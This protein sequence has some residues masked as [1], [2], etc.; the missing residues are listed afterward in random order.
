MNLAVASKRVSS[1]GTKVKV[2]V[3]DD[4]AVVRGLTRR[5]LEEN[6][7]I[8]VV[9]TA[10][11]GQLAVDTVKQKDID[12]VVLDIEMPVMDG[13][14]AIPH[15]LAAKPSVKIVMSSTL[16]EA[17]AAVSLKALSAGASD[18]VAKPTTGSAI[19]TSDDF[20][21]ELLTKV[22]TLGG[23]AD[24][25]GSVTA[26]GAAA[27]RAAPA[28]ALY[29]GKPITLRRPSAVTPRALAI[30]SSTGGPQALQ[31]L[32]CGLDA[33]LPLPVFITQ[34]MPAT[35]TQ[36]LAEHM[37]RDSGR[38]VCEAKNGQ[39]V[40]AGD[41]YIAPGDYHMVIEGSGNNLT[42]RLTQTEREN[43]CRPSVEPMLRSLV[44]IYGP[45]LFTVILTGM[46]HDGLA[47]CQLSVEKGG[48]V[49]AQDEASSV[50][51]GMPGAVATAGVCAAVKPLS[52][53]AKSVN[54]FVKG[55]RL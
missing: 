37:A 50:V 16:T 27:G 44:E 49:I 52:E 20:R 40:R 6:P 25:V 35:F 24:R 33:S 13:L 5:F 21:R 26:K 45:A 17:N 12:V 11:N 29:P 19:Q 2:L 54:S 9:A 32:L 18:Y 22:L 53:L 7:N 47:G 3:V 43:Y 31:T 51:W 55:G 15:I 48:T 14:S 42:I 4:S 10:S 34:H 39:A 28:A 23:L 36:I 8:D 41:I 30:G 38:N 1:G 46:G